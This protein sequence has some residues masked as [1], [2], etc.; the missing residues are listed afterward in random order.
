VIDVR[1]MFPRIPPLPRPAPPVFIDLVT[2]SEEEEDDDVK[3]VEPPAPAPPQ[4]VPEQDDRCDEEMADAVK[5]LSEMKSIERKRKCK[6]FIESS[7][8]AGRTIVNWKRYDALE[9]GDN[10]FVEE[11]ECPLCKTTG[12]IWGVCACAFVTPE[13]DSLE[14]MVGRV[15]KIP[16]KSCEKC[17]AAK[18][19]VCLCAG[20]VQERL[21]AL[22]PG[23]HGDAISQHLCQQACRACTAEK[24]RRICERPDEH[25]LED[26]HRARR[27]RKGY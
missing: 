2:S 6:R 8:G 11:R 4:A 18:Q 16:D 3:I 13:L 7:H 20:S 5:L 21:Q 27:A 26:S 15:E 25:R 24:V 12:V 22:Y 23:L 9:K 19:M 17:G 14:S 1:M 10:K